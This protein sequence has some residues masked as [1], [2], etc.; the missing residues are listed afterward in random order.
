MREFGKKLLYRFGVPFFASSL[1]FSGIAL[2]GT[3]VSYLFGSFLIFIGVDL[4][5]FVLVKKL[6]E[7]P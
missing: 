4:F 6:Q 2:I 3:E 1:V 5:I 7:K